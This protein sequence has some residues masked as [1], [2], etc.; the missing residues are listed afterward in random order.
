MD[1][2]KAQPWECDFKTHPVESPLVGVLVESRDHPDLEPAL[3]NFSCMLPYA[4]LCIMHSEKNKKR[5]LKIL[6]SEPTNVKLIPL[7]EPFGRDE[8]MALW[9]SENFWKNFENFSRVLIFNI[10]TG[11]RRNTILRFM[12]YDY[13]GAHWEH[14]PTPDPRV[15]QGNGGFSLRNPRIMAEICKEKCPVPSCEDI[16]VGWTL[17]NKVP[18]AVLPESRSV[19]AEFSTEGEDFYGT[20]GFHDTQKYTPK[21]YKVYTVADGPSR[22][23]FRL[24]S[25]T[26]DGRD[27]TDLVRL[28]IGPNCLRVFNTIG[29]GTLIINGNKTFDLECVI[30]LEFKSE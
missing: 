5:I 3:R 21:A 12:H 2:F 14:Q 6:G 28:G 4:S 7:P 24:D 19:C 15:F 23:L 20:L 1:A 16:W 17:V 10:D 30:H 29:R 13:V 26:L 22:R 9:T 18:G 25:A 8:C 27:V 11:I